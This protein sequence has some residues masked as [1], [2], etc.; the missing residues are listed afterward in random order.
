MKKINPLINGFLALILLQTVFIP[1]FFVSAEGSDAIPET[2]AQSAIVIDSRNG[3]IL[4]EHESEELVEIASI[5]KLLTVYLV[6]KSVEEGDMDLSD[7]VSISDYAYQVSQDYDVANVPLRQDETYTMEEL[8]ESVMIAL[9]NGSTIA[10]AEHVA[11]D[12]ASFVQQMEDQLKAWQIDEAVLLNS[13]G[14]PDQYDPNDA[15]SIEK[16]QQNQLSAEAVAVIAYHLLQEYPEVITLSATNNQLFR[17]GS[18]DE[19]EMTNFNLMLPEREQAYDQVDGLM[20][21]TSHNDG[22]SFVGTTDRNGFRVISVVLG[23]E[24]ELERYHETKKLFDYVYSAYMLEEIVQADESVTQISQLKIANGALDVAPIVYGEDLVLIVPVVDTAPRLSYEFIPGD[25]LE[26]KGELTAPIEQGTTVG[27]VA[28]NVTTN[29]A[30]FLNSTQGNQ[31]DVVLAETVD[32]AP[33]YSLTWQFI[34]EST[35]GG[36]ENTRRFFM[37]LFN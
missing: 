10:L 29:P 37:N 26:A 16:G 33:W 14:L 6:L 3:Q 15:D 25:E 18:S 2:N 22:G 32:P 27:Q 13:T 28:I 24:H 36:W 23:T 12:E 9:A 8:L 21:G 7:P 34:S 11:G 17:K 30:E 19:F 1:P 4:F 31:V 20:P 35:S 5:S